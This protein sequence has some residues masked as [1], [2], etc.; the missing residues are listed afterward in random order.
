MSSDF[1]S[2]LIRLKKKKK[3]KKTWIKNPA[4]MSTYCVFNYATF[5]FTEKNGNLLGLAPSISLVS[6]PLLV[7]I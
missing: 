5:K 4:S 7:F 1:D 6:V 2:N 3:K